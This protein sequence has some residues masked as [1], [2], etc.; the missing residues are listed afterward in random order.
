MASISG[1][2]PSN[3]AAFSSTPALASANSGSTPIAG[4]RLDRAQ[5]LGRGRFDPVVDGV[6]HPHRGL[7]RSMAHQLVGVLARLGA[8]D[9]LGL[10]VERAQVGR[11]P[12]RRGHGHDHPGQRGIDAGAVQTRPQQHAE[13]GVGQRPVEAP[14]VE[15]HQAGADGHRGGEP[16]QAERAGVEDGDHDDRHQ[17]VDDG[18]RGQEHAQFHRHPVAEKHDQRNRER[19]VGGY[20]GA[21]AGGQRAGRRDR[22]VDQ[23]RQRPCRRTTRR[24]AAPRR[25]TSRGGPR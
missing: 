22:D 17:V 6:E 5:Q 25:A 1:R 18:R 15:R 14:A 7:R 2:W 11:R 12:R 24:S 13:H 8:K 9:Q 4:P 21:P 20:R 19:G 16:G 10:G 23:R 3:T